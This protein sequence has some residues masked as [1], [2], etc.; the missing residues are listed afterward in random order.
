[1]DSSGMQQSPSRPDLAIKTRMLRKIFGSKVA[2]RSLTLEVPRGEV[3]GFLGPNGAGKSTSIKMML[4]LIAPTRGEALVLG[5]PVGDV[6][7]RRKI[8]FL[9]EHFRFYEWLTAI[10]LLSV[11]GRLY[12]MSKSRLR[13][14][15]P[16]LLNEVGLWPHREKKVRDFSKGM[17]QRLGLAQAL[18]NEP[19]L[20]FLDEPT[21][22]LDP[23]GRK[24]VRDI[25]KAQ[26]SRGAT[27]FLNSHLLGEV[28]VT[29]DRVGFIK[30]GEVVETRRLGGLLDGEITVTMRAGN[31]SPEAFSALAQRVS[32]LEAAGDQVTFYTPSMETLPGIVRF[33]V[34]QNVDVYE[35]TPQRLSLEDLFLRIVGVDGEP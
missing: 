17:M 26:R 21:S 32:S 15:I 20:I 34:S 4:G 10:E 28:E 12:G 30:N 24:L 6:S 18:L 5:S 13:E 27:V 35:I 16:E 29:C 1:M 23:A 22:G 7:V 25:I 14:R 33:L 8:G 11:H 31:L 19:D 9:P 3:F 2:V